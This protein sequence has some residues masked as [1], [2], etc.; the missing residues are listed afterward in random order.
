MHFIPESKLF[1][2]ALF[3]A[4]AAG[5]TQPR[6]PA[7]VAQDDSKYAEHVRTTDFQTPAQEQK[8]FRLPPGFEITLFAS[9][10]QIGKP[11]NIEFDDRGRLWVT[12]ST[13]YPMAADEKNGKDKIMI[14]EDTDH[15]GKAD[16]FTEFKSGLNIPIGIMPMTDGAIAYSIPD[17]Y[18]FKDKDHDGKA[19]E[20]VKLLGP[21]GYKDTH[22]M[23]NNL[24][25]GFD[26][27]VHASHGFSNTSRIAGADGD[28]LV[29][30]SGNTFR[31]RTDGS[32]AEQTTFGRVNPFGF[33]YDEKGYLYSVDCHSKPLYQLIP[34]ADYPH[35]GK[36]PTGIG[37]GP[38][39]T[40]Y[41]LASTAL[42]GLVYYTGSNF[43]EGYRQNFYIGD[44]VTSRISRN[45]VRFEG[46]TP[47]LK[48]EENFLVSSDP[49]F[50]PVDIKLGPDG[51]IYVADFYNRII[52]H[53]EVDL[54]HPGRDHTSGRIWRITYK[55]G[56]IPAPRDWSKAGLDELISQLNYPQLNIRMRIADRIFDTFGAR[57]V[58]PL[59]KVLASKGTSWQARVQAMWLLYRLNVLHDNMLVQAAGD[60][61]ENIKVHSLRIMAQRKH[62]N[63][64][65]KRIATAACGDASPFVRRSAAEV[66]DK[67]V[68]LENL[69]TLLNMYK[70]TPDLDSH[71]KYT[72]LLAL[73]HNVAGSG[74]AAGLIQRDW[75]PED[76][77]I[78]VRAALD[79]P[80]KT[81]AN[82]VVAYLLKQAP[83]GDIS[84]Q[85]LSYVA[86][87]VTTDQVETLASRVTKGL[88]SSDPRRLAR[89]QAI[90]DGVQK[91]GKG[92]PAGLSGL[93]E[94]SAADV[95][96]TMSRMKPE[97]LH[98][99]PTERKRVFVDAAGVLARLRSHKMEGPLLAVLPLGY[100]LELQQAAVS[101]LS[102][103]AP[104][105]YT[106]VFTD[107]F[108]NPGTSDVYRE[109]LVPAIAANPAAEN[110]EKL[111]KRL[112]GSSRNL[113]TEIIM[114]LVGAPGGLEIVMDAL[115][116][117][118]APVD[119]LQVKRV[120]T[121]LDELN[122]KE[123]NKRLS[124]L[125]AK[126][127]ASEKE[128][129]TILVTREKGALQYQGSPA[130]GR[131][132]FMQ[133]CS[134]CH[135]IKGVGGLVGPQLDGVGNWGKKAL[136]EKVLSPNRNIT[137]AFKTYQINLTSGEQKLGLYRR[138]EG[139]TLVFADHA[140]QE[141]SVPENQISDYTAVNMTIM[142]D[143]FRYTIP[144]NDFYELLTYLTS[145]K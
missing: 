32:R 67:F 38:E 102:R 15:D 117:N 87:Y 8:G 1:R 129:E 43:P 4:L 26:G 120:K 48:F 18:Y 134:G 34:G 11:M 96:A 143:Q 75:A 42:S 69:T 116:A 122:R 52:G 105:A 121:Y 3:L 73:R 19:D 35:F 55:G 53:Y 81:L 70:S 80:D 7:S 5:C 12:Q 49:W 63:P 126:S 98:R 135:Q 104:D 123:K 99:L 14:L 145:A 25:R 118:E 31:F 88:Q 115:E 24:T 111:R 76:E 62:I 21:F 16:V 57:A 10:P 54:K 142:P 139:A 17:L 50:R 59:Q 6:K 46:S 68:S 97:E 130:K 47:A 91:T 90:A 65:L 9:E 132:V 138:K 28:S 39:M 85:A 30:Y 79:V 20:S 61:E 29:M 100:P 77:R 45:S 72:V 60:P 141:F 128:L 86:S 78:L 114:A 82:F 109:K 66:L 107:L 58:A 125:L 119:L 133:N 56:A 144:E 84:D 140:G 2:T 71:L 74:V 40:S 93:L 33:S 89:L 13:E 106:K 51:A 23:I 108:T 124:A 112:P 113:Q 44:V 127:E 131:Q 83:E 64:E 94:V 36:K 95:I 137:E 101:A 37:F 22:G 41:Q 27:W 136:I 110:L 92:T 103:Y